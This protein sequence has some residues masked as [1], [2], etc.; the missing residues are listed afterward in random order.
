MTSTARVN[1]DFTPNVDSFAWPLARLAD[2]KQLDFSRIPDADAGY[3]AKLFAENL[4]HGTVEIEHSKSTERLKLAFD[5]ATTPCI[6]MWLNYSGWSGADTQPYFNVGIEPTSSNNDNLDKAFLQ[7][8]ATVLQAG[9]TC[10]WKMSVE[11]LR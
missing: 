5:P 4:A 3:A 7:G 9:D 11:L 2:G 8:Q 1:V 10:R 6:G